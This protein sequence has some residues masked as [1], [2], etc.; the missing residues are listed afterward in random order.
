MSCFKTRDQLVCQELSEKY[1]KHEKEASPVIIS[2]FI[3]CPISILSMVTK[4]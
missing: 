2:K 4:A 1:G 3:T